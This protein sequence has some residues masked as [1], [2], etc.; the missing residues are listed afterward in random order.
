MFC[1]IFLFQYIY[2]G[3]SEYTAYRVPSDTAACTYGFD[4]LCGNSL[5]M[6]SEKGNKKI[7][8]RKLYQKK[9]LIL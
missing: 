2:I 1:H 5:Y 6:L 3:L 4:N 8:L 9:D 7:S